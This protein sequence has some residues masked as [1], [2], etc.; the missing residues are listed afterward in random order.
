MATSGNQSF[1][2][3]IED[4]KSLW[5]A[6]VGLKSIFKQWIEEVLQDLQQSFQHT[7]S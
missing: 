4:A 5:T 6:M 2:D 3:D 7:T 1:G